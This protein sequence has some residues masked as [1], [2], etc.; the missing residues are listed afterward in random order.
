MASR[1]ARAPVVEKHARSTPFR[2]VTTRVPLASAR[3]ASAA[4]LA[5]LATT[6]AGRPAPRC[7]QRSSLVVIR[8]PPR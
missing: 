8:R 7:R 1:F 3:V 4:T 5:E 6:V 2:T